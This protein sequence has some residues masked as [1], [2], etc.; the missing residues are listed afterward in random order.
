[1]QTKTSTYA[2]YVLAVLWCVMLLRMVDLQII[3]VLFPGIKE[4]FGFSDTQLGMISGLSFSLFYSILG[5]PI[6]YL[7][8]RKNRV[9]ILSGCLGLWSA[10]TAACG[11]VSGFF[12][13]AL[14]RVGVGIGEAGAYPSSVSLV[15]HYFPP[16]KRAKAYSILA[17]TTPL[18]VFVSFVLG[19]WI[20]A[21]YGWR[22][23]FLAVGI[24]GILLALLV[25]FTIKEP[26][27]SPAE[28]REPLLT[29]FKEL[30]KRKDFCWS[31]IAAIFTVM[32]STGSG[33]WMASYF[34]RVHEVG[35]ANVGLLMGFIYGIG[36]VGGVLA[37]SWLA[38]KYAVLRGAVARAWVCIGSVLAVIPL[39]LI[40]FTAGTFMTAITTLCFVVI[41]MHMNIGIV[42]AIEQRAVGDERRAMGQA[43]HVLM[44]N[45]FGLSLGPI[46]VGY[47]SDVLTPKYG[48]TGL[49]Y[50]I[51]GIFIFG[52]TLAA[53]GFYMASKVI[54]NDK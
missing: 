32:A 24:P 23:A 39:A 20:S 45:L 51:L 49:G 33:I 12:T 54:K 38:E 19:G 37:G 16:E 15:S 11:L 1:M 26:V 17:S 6:A 3:S 13:F 4:E 35:T 44:T 46:I 8:D 31:V 22:A 21:T 30:W 7:L 41:A 40:M 53:L 18:G 5:I 2:Y 29:T 25:K 42:T 14:A 9:A 43:F 48:P 50:S 28:K 36:G 34:T 52:Y 27:R 10:M 47:F